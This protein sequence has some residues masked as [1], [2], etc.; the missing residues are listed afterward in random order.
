[1]Q[2]VKTVI[3]AFVRLT[4]A[5]QLVAVGAAG[6]ALATELYVV[7]F[8]ATYIWLHFV[9][10]TSAVLCDLQNEVS[11]FILKKKRSCAL[12]TIAE[13]KLQKMKKKEARPVMKHPRLLIGALAVIVALTVS[14]NSLM[15]DMS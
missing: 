12:A 5:L 2:Y 9:L 8:I 6:I 7:L 1:M 3:V 13:L 15:R 11:S 4:C 14:D 10:A